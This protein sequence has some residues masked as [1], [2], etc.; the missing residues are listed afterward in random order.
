MLWE[1]LSLARMPGVCILL[2]G[3][4]REEKLGIFEQGRDDPPAE[5][6]D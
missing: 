3:R 5:E 6:Q 4:E 2:S 1:N